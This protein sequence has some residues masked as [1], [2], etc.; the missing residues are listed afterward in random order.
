MDDE[1]LMSAVMARVGE[2]CGYAVRVVLDPDAFRDEYR[3]WSP[4]FIILDLRMPSADG[5]ELLRFLAEEK[6]AA[7]ILIVS[8]VESKLLDSA[9]RLGSARGL[10]LVG[11][12]AK[13]INTEDLRAILEQAA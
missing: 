11:S 4:T 10:S 9:E 8:G 7:R 6:S 2:S 13:P 12:L 5:I 3:S 1:P